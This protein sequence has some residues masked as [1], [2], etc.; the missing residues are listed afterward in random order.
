MYRCQDMMMRGGALWINYLN[1]FTNWVAQ[2]DDY[3]RSASWLNTFLLEITRKS[4]LN[5]RININMGFC[6]TSTQSITGCSS[7]YLSILFS[8][9]FWYI[10]TCGSFRAR[11]YSYTHSL[12]RFLS[13]SLSL[14][15]SRSLTHTHTHTHTHIYIYIYIYTGN[16]SEFKTYWVPH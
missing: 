3:L 4:F 14:S 9:I 13:R 7:I 1:K 11:S 2:N 8:G 16:K 5:K 15:L 10:N 6:Q 12:P